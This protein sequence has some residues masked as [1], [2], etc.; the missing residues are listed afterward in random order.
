MEPIYSYLFS[1]QLT[2]TEP[3]SL[4]DVM[5]ITGLI[6]TFYIANQAYSRADTLERRI[7]DL[8]Q[9]L[10]IRLSDDESNKKNKD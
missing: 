7:Q 6:F 5:L 1:N 4:F 8:H 3:L 9:E 10:S 2:T